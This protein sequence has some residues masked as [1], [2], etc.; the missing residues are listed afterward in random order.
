[1]AYVYQIG[2]A[3]LSVSFEDEV[4]K[5]AESE[6]PAPLEEDKHGSALLLAAGPHCIRLQTSFFEEDAEMQEAVPPAPSEEDGHGVLCGSFKHFNCVKHAL[7]HVAAHLASLR[8]KI[9]YDIR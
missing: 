2:G 7:Q 1:M 4:E 3:V 5:P 9:I 8:S 6:P